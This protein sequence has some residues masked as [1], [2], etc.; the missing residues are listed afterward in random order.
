MEFPFALRVLTAWGLEISSMG[1]AG[2]YMKSERARLS[3][4]SPLWLHVEPETRLNC[5]N[6]S[7]VPG[8]RPN[9]TAKS[10][11][12]GY[13]DKLK[14]QAKRSLSSWW[15]YLRTTYGQLRGEK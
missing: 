5:G 8:Q 13:R 11:S 9:V 15:T 4:P 7:G 12:A 1:G 14:S 3:P 2:C 10:Q 6:A